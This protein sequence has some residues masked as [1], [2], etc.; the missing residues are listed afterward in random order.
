MNKFQL[1][2][3]LQACVERTND[4]EW[5]VWIRGVYLGSIAC[6]VN[7]CFYRVITS[8]E[9]YCGSKN[10]FSAALSCFMDAAELVVINEEKA[11]VERW[12]DAVTRETEFR[13]WGLSEPKTLWQKIK[14]WFK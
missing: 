10:S 9:K 8:K 3:E 2:T 4:H 1:M 11:D 7:K 14:G 5:A 13:R 12:I 6:D